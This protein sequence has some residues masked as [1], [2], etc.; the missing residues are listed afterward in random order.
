MYKTLIV[1]YLP[2]AHAIFG[3]G[4]AATTLG[5][6]LTLDKVSQIIESISPMLW[7]IIVLMFIRTMTEIYKCHLYMKMMTLDPLYR[8]PQPMNDR[9]YWKKRLDRP[10]TRVTQDVHEDV[11]RIDVPGS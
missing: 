5:T 8:I 6:Y 9:A 11:K 7:S 4:V 1:L 2:G 3:W 10:L